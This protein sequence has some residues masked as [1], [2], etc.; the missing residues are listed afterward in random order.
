[1]RSSPIC[2]AGTDA[3]EAQSISKKETAAIP[4]RLEG[5][6]WGLYWIDRKRQAGPA[7]EVPLHFLLFRPLTA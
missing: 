7:Y 3:E 2:C 6:M 4:G 5:R 1:L